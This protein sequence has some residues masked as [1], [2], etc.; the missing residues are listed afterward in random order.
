MNDVAAAG[1][2]V[3]ESVWRSRRS[4]VA[5][6]SCLP[7]LSWAA[8]PALRHIGFLGGSPAGT[9][10]SPNGSLMTRL[11]ELGYV[12]GHN[13]RV[14]RT[15]WDYSAQ[16]CRRGA[17]EL[18]MAGV[19]VI[20]AGGSLPIGVAMETTKT[21][22]IVMLFAGDPIGMKYVKSL[23]RPGGNVTGMAWDPGAGIA[24]KTVELFREAVPKATAFGLLWHDE[25]PSH[26]LYSAD[27]KHAFE[28][29]GLRF[30]PIQ[31]RPH[32]PIE[33]ALERAFAQKIDGV[34]V[35]PDQFT[36]AIDEQVLK[37]TRA[38]KLPVLFTAQREFG[39]DGT[40]IHFSPDVRDH[41]R[42]GAE[43]VA[44]I[45]N[46]ARPGDLPIEQTSRFSLTVNLRV[47]ESLGVP[48]PPGLL[49]RADVVER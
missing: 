12:E 7:L 27:A 46:G 47:A 37:A 19:E 42:R 18:V 15:R 14:A 45:L 43:Y 22:P 8:S 13:L 36:G 21:I 24:S 5:A 48:I 38:R 39:Y 28:R 44:R 20:V 11:R 2:E 33:P 32:L 4:F 41:G 23:A 29:L 49:A 30:V 10:P 35:L 6:A 26:E 1:C 16:D 25:D 31:V 3:S 17:R 40:L 34:M 9:A